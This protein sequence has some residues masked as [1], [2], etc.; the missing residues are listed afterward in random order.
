LSTTIR[1]TNFFSDDESVADFFAVTE[2]QSYASAISRSISIVFDA[3]AGENAS[4]DE[5]DKAVWKEAS[6]R[7][8]KSEEWCK[9]FWETEVPAEYKMRDDFGYDRIHDENVVN[10]KYPVFLNMKDPVYIDGSELRADKI[11][12]L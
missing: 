11:L 10:Y 4:E 6:N 8:G 1:D 5:I 12:I 3:Y 2:K 9:H 7:T